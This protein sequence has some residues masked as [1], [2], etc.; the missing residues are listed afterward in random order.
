MG[1]TTLKQGYKCKV[2]KNVRL[3][4]I[5]ERSKGG[6]DANL[7]TPNL[8]TPNL[9]TPNLITPNLI[10]PNLITL[11]SSCRSKDHLKEIKLR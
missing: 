1:A 10:T 4:H 7:I 11:C 8:I 9:I 5:L 3:D 2:C 6:T